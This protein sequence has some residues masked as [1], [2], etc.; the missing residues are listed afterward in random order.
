[1]SKNTPEEIVKTEEVATEVS[2]E[3]TAKE[4]KK[5]KKKGRF[6]KNSKDKKPKKEET[7]EEKKERLEKEEKKA[8]LHTKS[9]AVLKEFVTKINDIDEET[10]EI[11]NS[12]GGEKNTYSFVLPAQSIQKQ[13]C[14]FLYKISKID[15]V[16]KQFDEIRFAY[17]NEKNQA[18]DCL[19]LKAE[20]G[21]NRIEFNYDNEYAE[22]KC[23]KKKK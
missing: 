11:K 7:E 14:E 22:L 23:V 8:D 12:Y 15:I 5:D 16:Q 18:M 13:E 19:F 6:G 1:M 17:Y 3:E 9:Q 21:W 2:A 4:E 20:Q 10:N